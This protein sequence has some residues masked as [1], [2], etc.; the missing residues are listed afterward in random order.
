MR[1]LAVISAGSL[2]FFIFWELRV[3]EPLVNLRILKNRNFAVACSCFLCSAQRF[4][5]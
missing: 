2:L 3:P 1:W 4:T 5:A